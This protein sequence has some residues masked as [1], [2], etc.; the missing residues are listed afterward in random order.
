[1]K[2]PKSTANFVFTN[3]H[4]KGSTKSADC[5]VRALSIATGKTWLQVY[6]ELVKLGRELLEL[7]NGNATYQNYLDKIATRIPAK[8]E[9]SRGN[10]RHTPQTLPKTGLYVMSQANHLVTIK[11]GRVRDT[12]DS[13]N[14]SAYI[15]WK[16]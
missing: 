1:M 3:P 16:F 5:V 12:W 11:N 4:P 6:D 9:G 14:K 13:S 7:P 8:Y 2:K 10:K 15:I